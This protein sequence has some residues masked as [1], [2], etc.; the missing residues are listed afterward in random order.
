MHGLVLK[1]QAEWKNYCKS[2][3]KPDDIPAYLGVYAGRVG[4]ALAIGSGLRSLQL[5][6]AGIVLSRKRVPT[7]VS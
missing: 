4:S 6:C 7:C 2:G 5:I 3:D 1:S